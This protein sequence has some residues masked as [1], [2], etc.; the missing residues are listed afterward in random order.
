MKRE[1]RLAKYRGRLADLEVDD[2][3]VGVNITDARESF[4]RIDV[5]VTPIEGQ[6]S[7]W[8]DSKRVTLRPLPEVK[9]PAEATYP[10]DEPEAA[11][12]TP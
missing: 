10:Q 12:V 4:G 6:G 8:V 5:Y 1:T 3:S 7:K 11:E 2:L 9:P